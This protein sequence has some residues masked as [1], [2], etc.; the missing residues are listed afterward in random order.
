MQHTPCEPLV[1]KTLTTSCLILLGLA[2]GACGG[3]GGPG[4]S[5]A[6]AV[7]EQT[8]AADPQYA[9]YAITI[10]ADSRSAAARRH[11][12]DLIRS[13][14]YPTALEA[15]RAYQ[16]DPIEEAREALAAV[17]AEKSGALQLQAAVA[18]ARLGDED[19]AVWLE[20]QIAGGAAALNLPALQVASERGK[21]DLVRDALRGPI[22]S[23]SLVTRNE[24]YAIL[25]TLRQPW[26]TDLL[27]QGL[28]NER[29]EERQQAI[30][31]LGRAGE[32][33]AAE[34]ITRF[35][36]T[37]GLVFATL[38]SLGAMGNP[39][40]LRVARSMTRHEEPLVRLYAAVATW[41]LGGAEDARPVLEPMVGVDDATL[42]QVLAEQLATLD[43]PEAR[44][45]LA[46]LCRDS[47]KAVRIAALRSL[48]EGATAADAEVFLEAA[49]DPDYEIATLGLNVLARVGSA[50]MADAIAG[51]LE[52]DNPYV[53]LS[54]A[55]AMLALRESGAAGS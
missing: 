47:E 14:H 44:E 2:L 55:H 12:I 28:D 38:E 9:S 8:L 11:V 10:A 29:G 35:I 15:V 43:A 17:F 19:A 41:R 37:Q 32:P 6:E 25:G 4:G 48:A 31:A 33:R 26:A 20:E 39:D 40:T 46:T 27:L 13:D 54:T 24:V 30:L 23:E 52:S 16:D 7:F 21:V 42:R 18:L 36:N 53:A 50:E 5:R 3:A 22:T 45:W 1:R 34:R 49:G 51:G